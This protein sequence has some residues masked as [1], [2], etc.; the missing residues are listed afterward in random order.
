MAILGPKKGIPSIA[1]MRMQRWATRLCAYQYHIKYR[2]SGEHSNADALYRLPRPD[3]LD[4]ATVDRADGFQLDQ[5][6]PLPVTA[7]VI[8]QH[9]ANDYILQR[10]YSLILSGRSMKGVDEDIQPYC[11][12]FNELSLT[13]GCIMRGHRVVVPQ[14][15]RMQILQELHEGHL[16]IVKMKEIARNY[17]WWP[18]LVQDIESL[19]RSCA[20]CNTTR[21]SPPSYHHSWEYRTA[22]WQRVHIDFAGPI[23]NLHF[24]ISD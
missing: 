3:I 19:A 4:G 23:N 11:R 15:L 17:I 13:Q 10:V 18:G 16:G 21:N 20:P 24:F 22:P 9:T 14:T 6:E 7:E 8:R 12:V 5:L 1:A 2:S